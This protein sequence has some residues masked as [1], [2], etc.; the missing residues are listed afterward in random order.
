[1]ILNNTKRNY[2]QIKLSKKIFPRIST[3]EFYDRLTGKKLQNIS[4]LLF[5]TRYFTKLD[6]T[7]E[8]VIMI[9][10]LRNDK[11]G[12]LAKF[13]IAQRR[14]H[15]LKYH[16]PVIGYSYDSNTIGAHI[17]KQAVHALR[18]G[19]KIAKKNGYNLAKFILDLKKRNPSI[20]IR[21]LGHSL[22]S[23]VILSTIIKLNSKNTRSI[24]ESVHFFGA[25]IPSDSFCYNKFGKIA[26][27]IVHTKIVNYYA[28]TDEV[29]KIADEWNVVKQPL[30]LNGAYGKTIKKF[31]QKKVKPKNHRFVSYAKTLCSY[32]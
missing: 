7:S 12:A 3:R 5:P 1:M 28:P 11:R 15:H 21:L 20:K 4:Y 16:W 17:Q 14:L 18:I 31:V 25:S 29:L 26:Q 32:P 2:N 30:G 24:I 19:E 22:G 10:G 23:L 6:Q 13:L 27:K 9:H 8:I